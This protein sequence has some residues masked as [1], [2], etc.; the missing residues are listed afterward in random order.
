MF[1]SPG[2]IALQI[3]SI[4]IYWYGIFMAIAI[5]CGVFFSSKILQ[6]YYENINLDIFYDL[7]FYVLLGGILGARLYYVLCNFSYFKIHLNEILMLWNGGIS[8]HGALLGG[9]LAGIFYVKRKNLDFFLYA[10]V[11]V[12]G[13]CLGQ[14]IGRVGNFFNSEAFGSPTNLP[15]KLF[16]PIQHRPFGY[17]NFSY[18][19]PTFLYEILLNSVILLI[20]YFIGMRLKF[21]KH[22]VIFFTYLILYSIIRIFIENIRIDSVLDIQGIPIA[23]IMS[24]ILLIGAFIGLIWIFPDKKLKK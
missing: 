8:I 22:G 5:F 23:I 19:H 24:S 16:I 2:A 12:F 18:F 15:W 1:S 4:S 6:K 7:I 20:L 14:I 3:G 9:L 11:I 17:E 21:Q 13:V 10:D